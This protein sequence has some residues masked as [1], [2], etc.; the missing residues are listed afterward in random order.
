VSCLSDVRSSLK[1]APRLP[2]IRWRNEPWNID[3]DFGIRPSTNGEYVLHSE[4]A[5][6]IEAKDAKKSKLNAYNRSYHAQIIELRELIKAAEAE[7]AQIKAQVPV[8]FAGMDEDGNA[9]CISL[10]KTGLCDQP[11]YAAPVSDGLKA[12]CDRYK[13]ALE[14]YADKANWDSG[15]FQHSV[16]EHLG[17]NVLTLNIPHAVN[18]Q[19]KIARAALN[20]EASNDKG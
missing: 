4:A 3:D 13:K 7:L 16:D 12:K 10:E 5:K 11:L 15:D 14:F 19:G 1:P 20:V 6:I 9:E 18:D 17:H 2:P 8:M